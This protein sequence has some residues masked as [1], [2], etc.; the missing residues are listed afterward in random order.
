MPRPPKN[1]LV[2]LPSP[3]GDA[4][5]STP[6]LRAL[7]QRFDQSR[8][9]LYGDATVRAVLSPSP[10]GDA[11][12]RPAGKHLFA[13]TRQLRERHFDWAILCKNSLGSALVCWL[14]RIPVRVGYAREGRGWLLTAGLRPLRHPDGSF[15][16]APM[17]DYYLSLCHEQGAKE[18][19]RRM[20]LALDPDAVTRLRGKRPNGL[21]GSGPLVVLVPGGGFGPSKCWPPKRFARVADALHE[22]HG[23]RIV[24]SV[25]PNPAEHAIAAAITEHCTAPL[26]NLADQALDLGELKALY[27]G[28]DLVVTNDTGPRHIALALQRKVVTLFGPNDPAWTQTG[29]EHERQIIGRAPCAPCQQPICRAERHL[30]MESIT[31][32]EVLQA[33]RAHLEG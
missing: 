6:A 33:A 25:A 8:I 30:C 7:R 19:D 12:L 27:A 29:C 28:A 32:S 3:L 1:I 20:E 16:P 18:P 13:Q 23:A 31:V 24:L 11:W 4:V 26:L 21:A 15:R 22:T 10:F 17:I 5:M 2:W 9:T 14:A